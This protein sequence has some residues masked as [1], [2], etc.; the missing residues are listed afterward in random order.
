[1]E[2]GE[3]DNCMEDIDRLEVVVEEACIDTALHLDIDKGIDPLD[4]E[5]S[6][7]TP[8][9]PLCREGNPDNHC[10]RFQLLQNRTHHLHQH[11]HHH[12][13]CRY[14]VLPG[15]QV[16]MVDK[17]ELHSFLRSY[18]SENLLGGILAAAEKVV[19]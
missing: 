16:V 11:Q 9:V 1:M 12:H 4:I 15:L 13:W 14:F 19:D 2:E 17:V 8:M 6:V 10:L 3:V 5:V 7:S 18:W